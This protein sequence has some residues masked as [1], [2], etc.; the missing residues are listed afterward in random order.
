MEYK[1]EEG[2]IKLD[3]INVML[4]EAEESDRQT[5]AEMRSSVLLTA[6]EHYSKNYSQF[7][8]RLRRASDVSQDNKI[9]LVKNHIQK[10]IKLYSNNLISAAPNVKIAPQ[11]PSEMQ[12]QKAAEMH[13][14][15]WTDGVRRY[16]LDYKRQNW[17]DE[18]FMTAEIATKLYWDPDAGEIVGYEQKI[19]ENGN[20]VFE[21]AN[22][23]PV[24]E[25]TLMALQ[26]QGIEMDVKP[27]GDMSKPKFSGDFKFEDIFP[28]N[29]LRDAAAK[30]FDESPWLAIRKM[31][32]VKTL[33]RQFPD[34][35]EKIQAS[36]DKTYLV[37]DNTSNGYRKSDKDEALV[38]EVYWRPCMEYPRGYYCIT[39][40]DCILDEGE[41]PFGL[42][43]IVNEVADPSPTVPRGRS[44]VRTL[45]PYQ[46]E[47]N[48]CASKIAEHQMTLG[49]DKLITL[50][51]SKMSAGASLSGVR[52]VKVTGQAPIVLEG[53]AGM[54]YL[55][56]MNSQIDEMYK[57]AMVEEDMQPSSNGQFDAYAMLYQS[58]RKKKY[59]Q[60]YISRFLRFQRRLCEL[61]LEMARHYFDENRV[62][63]VVGK[64]EQV[65]MAEF[66]NAK[67]LGYQIVVEESSDDPESSV[68][69]QMILSQIMQYAQG[70]EREDFGKLIKNMP[71]ANA[72]EIYSDLTIN[73]ENARNLMLALERGEMPEATSADSPEYMMSKLN[74]RMKEADFKFLHPFIQ[75]NYQ[76]KL[77]EYAMIA[78]E[79]RQKIARDNAGQIPTTGSLIGVDVFV[80]YDPNDPT[81]SRRA[82]LPYDAVAWLIQKLEDQGTAI[83]P[84]NEMPPELQAQL[85]GMQAPGGAMPPQGGGEM[86]G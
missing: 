85:P 50:N 43:P 78:E 22:G 24:D 11:I 83:G 18:F 39:T 37:F 71:F 74:K 26:A 66:K 86:M 15:V 81:K 4:R 29:L 67:P 54:Q 82:R 73:Y 35:A 12:D 40:E 64:K 10:I 32:K 79:N 5:F 16:D 65:N 52:E 34:H 3:D 19:D 36:T 17:S 1:K 30:T 41:L 76:N 13:Q 2:K 84:I 14:A 59:F 63:H 70:L 33:K 8:D 21:D 80:N 25:A 72:E 57:V 47:I 9:R 51:G 62:I 56:Y 31:A 55:E 44:I 68:G 60:R 49:D 38:R 20:P 61:Y 69:K 23:N 45:R 6:G 46:V 27:V 28:A 7:M 53:R 58:A 75:Q 42:F 77:Q 48:R